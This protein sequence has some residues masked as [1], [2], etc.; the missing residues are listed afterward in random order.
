MDF[1]PSEHEPDEYDPEAE[2]HDPT[3]DSLTIP[4]VSAEPGDAH[5]QVV[6]MFWALVLVTKAAVIA[7]SLG[8]LLLI[9]QRHTQFGW[10]LLAGGLILTG[11]A[12]YRYRSFDPAAFSNKDDEAAGDDTDSDG[13]VDSTRVATGTD[14][15]ARDDSSESSESSE[16]SHSGNTSE[17]TGSTRETDSDQ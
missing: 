6:T 10:V 15:S 12:I 3:S 2:F 8:L 13:P 7:T 17:S 16:S 4:Q 1:E 11:F 14:G 9:F 5:P